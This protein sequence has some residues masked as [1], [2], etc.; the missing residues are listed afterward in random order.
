MQQ[1]FFFLRD[2]WHWET[3]RE[4]RRDLAP[5]ISVPSHCMGTPAR[6]G[7]CVTVANQNKPPCV[8]LSHRVCEWHW[9]S[10]WINNWRWCFISLKWLSLLLSLS[11][12]ALLSRCCLS[13]DGLDNSLGIS[14]NRGRGRPRQKTAEEER[15]FPQSGD[16]HYAGVALPASHGK[17]L[18][19]LLVGSWKSLENG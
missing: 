11:R 16:Q 8:A 10:V 6:R 5:L 18:S 3:A 7:P 19:D 12:S 15:N 9:W 2:L 14:G 13:G 4:S 1:L 17:M